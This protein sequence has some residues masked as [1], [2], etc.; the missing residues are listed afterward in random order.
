MTKFLQDRLDGL[1]AMCSNL[2]QSLTQI[3][4]QLRRNTHCVPVEFGVSPSQSLTFLGRELAS[5][6]NH[7]QAFDQKRASFL[8]GQQTGGIQARLTSL[9]V[10]Q[11]LLNFIPANCFETRDEFTL[12]EVLTFSNCFLESSYPLSLW[13]VW[14]LETTVTDSTRM[15]CNSVARMYLP[16]LGTFHAESPPIL[17]VYSA[18]FLLLRKVFAR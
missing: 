6:I 2:S 4:M 11:R 18:T 7:A 9:V 16:D 10:A 17:W 13:R 12:P 8:S 15:C 5:V 3:V 1:M 14:P